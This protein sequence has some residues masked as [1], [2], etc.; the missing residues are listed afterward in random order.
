MRVYPAIALLLSFVICTPGLAQTTYQTDASHAVILDAETGE[1]LFSR[2]ADE[3]MPPAS[4]SKMMTVLMLI[5]A[6]EAGSLS[7]DDELPVSEYA[8]R[9]GGAASGSSTMFL[10]VNSRARVDDLLRGIIIQSGNDACIVVAEA[11]GGSE[12]AFAD[13]MTDRAHELGLTSASFAN[14]TGWPHP[15]HRISALDLA[16]LARILIED[17]P[18]YYDIWSEREFT[19]NGIRQYNRN[20]LLGVFSG[21]DGLKTGHTEESG[22]GLVGSAER[23]GERRIIVFNGMSSNNDR[24]TEAERMMRSALSDYSLYR[25]FEAGDPVDHQAEVFMGEAPT[26]ALRVSSDV[27]AG[28]HR[29]A[30]RD[31]S[32]SVSYDGPLVA[33]VQEGDVVG[34]LTVEAP[35]YEARTYDLVAAESVAEK[36]LMGRIGAAIAHML[37]G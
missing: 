24:A 7:L 20:P 27:T 6:I 36:G 21:A 1:V 33:P 14:S 22:Y 32:V 31:L 12:A 30:R 28:L 35:D 25:L 5:E 34:T 4:M 8:W 26:V 11:I 17:H 2:N 10:E 23:D 19:Y 13:M 29:R 18:D 3:A 15:D 16:R 37:R 9:T